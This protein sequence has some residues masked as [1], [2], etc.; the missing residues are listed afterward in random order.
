MEKILT[1]LSLQSA[2]EATKMQQWVN[3]V[4]PSAS[5][6]KYSQHKKRKKEGET[7]HTFMFNFE[8]IRNIE[9]EQLNIWFCQ[10]Q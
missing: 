10:I 3:G 9:F 5:T 2:P 7:M 4:V 1:Y 8:S 6:T